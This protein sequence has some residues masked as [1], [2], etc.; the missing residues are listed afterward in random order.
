MLRP[1][2][3]PTAQLLAWVEQT[4]GSRARVVGWRRLTGGLTSIVHRLTVERNGRREDYVLRWWMPDG[5][6]GQWIARAVP[7]E[8]AVLTQ[9]E[10]SN[11][12]VPHVIG[13]I[14][15]AALGGPAILMTR[16][17]GKM[18]LTPR[19]RQRWLRQIARMLARIHALTLD[20][21]PFESWLDRTQLSPPPDA[22]RAEVWRE[23][24]ALVAEERAPARTCFVHRD[25][26]PFNMLW[27]RERLTGVVD[28]SEACIGPPEVDVGHC[29]LNLA[30]LFSAAV[31]DDF[32]AMY[33]AESGHTV[34]AWWDVHA[35]L[36]YG[37][38]WKQFLPIQIDGRAP[39]DVAGMTGRVEEVLERA[40]RP[41]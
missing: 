4:L 32:R 34:D 14:T 24:I 37:P 38:A 30:V 23:A 22:S 16:V 26:Q 29:R 33:E 28:W 20:G 40:L 2:A 18:Q 39:L 21:K 5:E 10:G 36:S 12:P 9:L 8:T 7:V 13:S 17:P 31:A 3:R 15:D 35:L 19:D 11:I 41:R 6:W 25:Y 27:S 1:D